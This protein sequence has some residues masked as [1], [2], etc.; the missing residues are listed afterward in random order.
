MIYIVYPLLIAALLIGSKPAKRGNWNE[1]A[2]SLEQMKMLQGLIA[3]MIMFH[4]TG[5]KTC[6]SWIDKKWVVPGLEFFVPIGFVLVA[7]FTFCSG[8]GLYK[9]YK[10]QKDYLKNFLQNI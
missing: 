7:F 10:T 6:A 3:L 4:H 2:F 1:D 8:Y 5:Q 9:S